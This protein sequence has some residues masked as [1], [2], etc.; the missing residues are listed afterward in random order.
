MIL[1]TAVYSNSTLPAAQRHVLC[2]Y[3]IHR[4]GL[5]HVRRITPGKRAPTVTELEEP[6][7]VA[8]QAMVERD[9]IAVAM[10]DLIAVGA[11]DVLVVKID[12]SRAG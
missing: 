2:T 3:N 10:D 6:G 11:T 1:E 5:E 4:S 8:V 7:W 9:R 12:N